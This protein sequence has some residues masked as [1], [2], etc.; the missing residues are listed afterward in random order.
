MD[1]ELSIWFS[2]VSLRAPPKPQ[3]LGSVWV[4]SKTVLPG[5]LGLSTHDL[6]SVLSLF[7]W[8]QLWE[9]LE[10]LFLGLLFTHTL[11]PNFLFC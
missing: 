3:V 11:L 6:Q 9:G 5:H 7:C 8:C 4:T 2:G 1:T 10:P